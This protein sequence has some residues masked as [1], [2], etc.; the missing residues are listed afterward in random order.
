MT[1]LGALAHTTTTRPQAA[2]WDVPW[3]STPTYAG[4]DVNN[5]TAF[6][7][8]TVYGCVRFICDGISTLPVDVHRK[9]GDTATTLETPTIIASPA[10]GIDFVE[11]ATQFLSSLLIDGNFYAHK[12]YRGSQLVEA[13]PLDPGCVQINYEG[14]RKRYYVDGVPRDPFEILHVRGI[15]W[16]GSDLG[17][18][19]LEAA[20]QSIGV[21][22]SA[23][24]YA[25]R[26]FGDDSTP[27]GVIELAGEATPDT[28]R[29]MARAWSKAHSG[30]SKRSL[31]GV[32]AGGAQWKPTA[33]TNEQAQ[34]LQTRKFTASEIAAQM[35]LIDPSEMGIGVE[36]QSLTYANLE[37]RNA[38]KVQVT[39][40]PWIIRLERALTSL[41]PRPQY[42]KLNV[43]GLLRGDT[44]SRFTA[45]ETGIRS[46]FLV[47]N[48][49]RALED[50]PPLP[51]GVPN[52]PDL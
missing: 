18:S 26:F 7:L 48:E 10:I 37:Q 47:P 12:L 23:Q 16:P 28:M 45:Y 17:L 34:F 32:L 29:E 49:A 19:P 3:S 50:M 42:V 20:R 52:E 8:L 15:M 1:V 46:G 35:F 44:G 51:P 25:A 40:L 27:P 41:L 21:G 13:V 36:G 4:V 31:P 5:D 33:V 24:E 2:I 9:R 38:R 43:N 11:W 6:Q 22:V 39:F 14:S 30:K